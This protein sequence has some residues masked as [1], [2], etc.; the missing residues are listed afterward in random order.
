[1]TTLDGIVS[2]LQGFTLFEGLTRDTIRQLCESSHAQVDRH[3]E[4]VFRFGE[5][6]GSFGIVLSGAYK[7]SRPTPNG[8]DVIV[9]FATPGDVVAA[10]IMARPTPVYPVSVVSMGPS[11]ILKI[12]RSTYVHHWIKNPELL[13]RIQMSL[14]GRMGLFQDQ[15]ALIRAPLAS[16]IAALL[17][18]LLDK[19]SAQAEG[20]LPLPLTRKEIADSLGSSVEAVIRVMSGWSKD[21]VLETSERHIQI[22]KPEILIQE[23][24]I[25]NS[26]L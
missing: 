22:L 15:K 3:H 14:S 12:P 18:S 10:F 21:G 7:L 11:R 16:K 1:M 13:T 25:K 2:E 20:F 26:P 4:F 5:E 19:Q 9:Y 17:I 23:F 6:A 8:E 24:S